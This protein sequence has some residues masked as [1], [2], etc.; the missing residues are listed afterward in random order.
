MKK[1][2]FLELGCT[3]DVL[4]QIYTAI[5]QTM[6]RLLHASLTQSNM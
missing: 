3:V 6:V 1:N 5:M 4:D 2:N